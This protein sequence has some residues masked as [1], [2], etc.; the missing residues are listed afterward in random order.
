MRVTGW[1]EVAEE[2]ET[3]AMKVS[4]TLKK[5]AWSEERQ[6]FRDLPGTEIYSQHTQVMAVLSDTVTGEDAKSLME[7]T[8]NE[9]MNQVSLPYSYL[10]IQALKKTGLQHRIFKL[11]DRWRVFISQGLT[12]LPEMEI[13]PRSDCHAWSAVPLAEFP[14]TI[15]G[16]S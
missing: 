11:W 10:L 7:R 13:N 14:S 3:R 4:Q 12:T 6:L 8:L 1:N 9:S 2:M 16:V 15:L 5:L